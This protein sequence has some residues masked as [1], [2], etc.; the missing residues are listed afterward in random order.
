[1]VR[2]AEESDH[3]RSP[4][5][6]RAEADLG[7]TVVG[8]ALDPVR[9]GL[10]RAGLRATGPRRVV[11]RAL[12]AMGGHRSADEVRAAVL[13]SKGTLGRA[14]VYN[15][16]D[17]LARSGLAMVADAGPGRTLYEAGTTW[18]HHAVCRRCGEVSDVACVVA[19]K[20]CLRPVGE[21]GEVDEAQVI[22]RGVCASCLMTDGPRPG[23]PVRTPAT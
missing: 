6:E 15:A 1:L 10:H 21:W 11:Y 13:A 4:R 14:S 16:L 20:P 22:F 7:N 2:S 3:R 9:D 18:H 8:D 12:V 19:R 23:D 17:A 5:G